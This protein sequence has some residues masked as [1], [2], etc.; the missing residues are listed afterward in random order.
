MF[1]PSRVT[2][3]KQP[4]PSVFPSSAFAR[5][6]PKVILIGGREGV[7]KTLSR[8][9]FFLIALLL[10]VVSGCGQMPVVNTHQPLANN[11]S[12]LGSPA[13]QADAHRKVYVALGDTVFAVAPGTPLV[14]RLSPDGLQNAM[15]RPD[16]RQPGSRPG[17][18]E[19]VEG[20]PFLPPLPWAAALIRPGYPTGDPDGVWGINLGV[21]ASISSL[22]GLG[23]AQ[24]SCALPS[25]HEELPSG[26]TACSVE[27]PVPSDS[28][29]YRNKAYIA[30]SAAY[31]TPLGEPFAINCMVRVRP[32]REDCFVRYHYS[33]DLV[34]SYDFNPVP[35]G[36]HLPID[37]VIDFDKRLRDEI[38]R[39][40]VST[41]R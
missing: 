4:R 11:P 20:I 6:A 14:V 2:Y 23:L 37:R 24:K 16:P 17:N 1:M 8:C 10:N 33:H 5:R 18:P 36:A 41:P 7:V 19:Q 31:T 9:G 15:P 26:L 21:D 13:S 27:P 35:P 34:V 32:P 38:T 3:A 40:I 30:R 22:T 29:N 25:V 12:T 39:L 28:I